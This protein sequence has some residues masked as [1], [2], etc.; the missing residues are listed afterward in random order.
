MHFFQKTIFSF[1][2]IYTCC[3][4]NTNAQQLN[5]NFVEADIFIEDHLFYPSDLVIIGNWLFVKDLLKSSGEYGIK[6]F[7]VETGE[8]VYEFIRPGRDREN[9]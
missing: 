4:L 6:V 8:K 3:A 5:K 9:I 1:F 7:N 2:L